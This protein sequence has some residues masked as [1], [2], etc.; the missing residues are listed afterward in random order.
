MVKILCFLGIFL[1]Y[2]LF[3]FSD[4]KAL[5]I[6]YIPWVLFTIS[7]ACL[8]YIKERDVTVQK[9]WLRPSIICFFGLIIVG[10]QLSI[11]DCLGYSS[12]EQS[13]FVGASQYADKSFFSVSIFLFAYILGLKKSQ[14]TL[15]NQVKN[16]TNKLQASVWLILMLLSFGLFLSSI[17]VRFYLSGASYHGSGAYDY[18]ASLT[19]SF[20]SLFQVFFHITLACYVKLLNLNHNQSKTCK[21]F[22]KGFPVLFWVCVV[23]YLILRLLSGDRGPV[24]YNSLALVYAFV[25]YSKYR[26]KF[27]IVIIT[28]VLGASFVTFLG[29]FRSR[30]SDLNI[31]E[32]ITET[33]ERRNEIDEQSIF[34]GTYE[35]ARSIDTHVLAIRDIERDKTTYSY[36]KY[37]FFSLLTSIPGLKTKYLYDLGFKPDEINSAM[38]FTI[39]SQGKHFNFNEGSSMFGESYLE[40]G[41][42]G[43]VII[44]FLL[45]S[46]FKQL[47]FSIMQNRPLSVI[48]IAVILIISE[49]AIYMGRSSF[50]YELSN[51]IHMLILYYIINFFIKKISQ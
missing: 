17:D 13:V 22:F 51:V 41:V 45:G 34:M 37:T 35:L 4:E 38:Y 26:F 24:I 28:L 32:K 2:I 27:S 1:S 5:S 11:D 50:S 25:W 36:G 29:T 16:D 20:E 7:I 43:M 47:D 19:N 21:N 15:F 40:L 10:Y 23:L 18:Q 44:G 33:V 6:L 30:S 42:L 14:N 9:F 48:C 12:L 46:I 3:L 8:Y 49:H 31:V 39:S